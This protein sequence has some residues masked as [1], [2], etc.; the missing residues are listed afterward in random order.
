MELSAVPSTFVDI[1]KRRRRTVGPT[2]LEGL[3]DSEREQNRDCGGAQCL[4]VRKSASWSA[5]ACSQD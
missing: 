5:A 3:K 4:G 2:S 1:V